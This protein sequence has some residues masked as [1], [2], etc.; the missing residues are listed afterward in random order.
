M[1]R[2]LLELQTIT[3]RYGVLVWK[4]AERLGDALEKIEGLMGEI[5]ALRA[6]DTHELVRLDDDK[7]GPNGLPDT[8]NSPKSG[9]RTAA[10][11]MQFPW[12]LNRSTISANL[13]LI[14]GMLVK[15]EARLN[16]IFTL[17]A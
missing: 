5:A 13:E 17:R 11:G 12:R 3:A 16:S 2:L 6:P 9:Y 1:D 15:W 14:W 7:I 8:A 10:E 4:H